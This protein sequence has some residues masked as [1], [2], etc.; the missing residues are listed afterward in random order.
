MKRFGVC[1]HGLCLI[2]AQKDFLFN[3]WITLKDP[4]PAFCVLTDNKIA[5]Q[6][7]KYLSSEGDKIGTAQRFMAGS[8]AGATAQTSI[9]PM[10]VSISNDY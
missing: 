5:F 4:E 6:Y 8:L 3:N 10:E 7:K 1:R 9:Y 2:A